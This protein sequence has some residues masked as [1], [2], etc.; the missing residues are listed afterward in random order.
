ML[1]TYQK[2]HDKGFEIVGISLDSDKAR[3]TS[4]IQ[5]KKMPWRQYFDGKQWENKL[6]GKYG[7]QSI[8]ATFLLDREGK[9]IDK[10]LRGEALEQA[11]A[12]AL[13]KN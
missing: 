12:S 13:A 1:E 4:F 9:I 5:T 11:V 3:L 7:V 8:P 10:D 6:A 2:Y